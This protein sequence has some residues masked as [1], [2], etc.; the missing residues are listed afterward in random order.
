MIHLGKGNFLFSLTNLFTIQRWNNR[1]AI[2][3]FSEA[4]N[5]FNTLFLSFLFKISEG[6]SIQSIEDSLKWRFTR[7][8][9]KIVLSDV[10]LQLKER[11]E[12]FSPQV[13][14]EV[15]EKSIQDLRKLSDEETVDFLVSSIKENPLDKIADLY[16]SYL[17]AYENGKLFD[18]SQ[19]LKELEE[20]IEKIENY[21]GKEKSDKLWD[22][23]KYSWP[24]I[25][26]LT[27]M[28]RWNRTHRNVRTTVSG[29]SFLVVT[30]A[31]L[32]AKL[33]KFENIEEVILKSVLHDLPEAFTGDVITPTKKKVPGLEELVNVVEREMIKEWINGNE[34]VK[35]LENY[36]E[37]CIEPFSGDSGRIVRTADYFAA[38][39]ECAV[40]V[41]SGNRLDVFRDSFFTFKKLIKEISPID[42]SEWIDEIE[43][44]IL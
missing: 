12:R 7:E 23:A 11:I 14:K 18:Y 26:N 28:V 1:P 42:V 40:E 30:I 36:V 2:I 37:Y 38:L 17:E 33:Y 8:L 44:L 41:H 4:D 24:A 32:I 16:V 27:S 25:L 39:L 9:P 29:H 31:Y 21:F 13:W 43:A 34:N 3:R 5:S 19:P 15:T 10:S 20:K 35:P 6:Q 22:T